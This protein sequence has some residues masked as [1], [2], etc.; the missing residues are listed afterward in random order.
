MLVIVNRRNDPSLGT[1]TE[2]ALSGDCFYGDCRKEDELKK[3]LFLEAIRHLRLTET[4]SVSDIPSVL[5]GMLT[6]ETKAELCFKEA[7]L[8]QFSQW[9]SK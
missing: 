1:F 6:L 9:L 8:R 5:Y 2:C 7:K 3:S 4:F